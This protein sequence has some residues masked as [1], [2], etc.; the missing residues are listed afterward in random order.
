[1]SDLHQLEK[2]YYSSSRDQEQEKS[3]ATL[4]SK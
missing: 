3:V 2:V 1:M 4:S